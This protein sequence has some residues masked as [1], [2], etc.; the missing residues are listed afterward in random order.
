MRKTR[1]LIVGS[2]LVGLYTM[3]GTTAY[4]L[5]APQVGVSPFQMQTALVDITI[6]ASSGGPFSH[7]FTP[8]VTETLVADGTE[9]LFD[10]WVKNHSSS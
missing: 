8:P 1:A 3:L 5:F 7:E 2:F 6:G 9:H 4:A 10:F